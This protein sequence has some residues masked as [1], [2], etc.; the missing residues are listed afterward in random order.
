MK[1]ILTFKSLVLLLSTSI[2]AVVLSI[3]SPTLAAGL[4]RR[5]LLTPPTD[6]QKTTSFQ[7]LARLKITL[8]LAQSQ[9]EKTAVITST[10]EDFEIKKL[11]LQSA[12]GITAKNFENQLRQHILS[13][14]KENLKNQEIKAQ[15]TQGR[16]T[17]KEALLPEY[18]FKFKIPVPTIYTAILSSNGRFLFLFDSYNK[19]NQIV[20]MNT[21]ASEPI[22]WAPQIFLKDHILFMQDQQWHSLDLNTLA[23]KPLSTILTLDWS[24]SFTV[25]QNKEIVADFNDVLQVKN[26]HFIFHLL[27]KNGSLVHRG[28]IALAET[29]KKIPYLSGD[30]MIIETAKKTYNYSFKTQLLQ[31]LDLEPQQNILPVKGTNKIVTNYMRQTAL[32]DLDTNQIQKRVFKDH[33]RAVY[34]HKDQILMKED[35]TDSS[36][37]YHE[38][39]PSDFMTSIETYTN[40][41]EL[42]VKEIPHTNWL[43]VNNMWGSWND[44]GGIVHSKDLENK[45]FSFQS[46]YNPNKQKIHDLLISPDG[47]RIIVQMTNRHTNPSIE[48]W[49]QK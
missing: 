19:Q 13:A 9:G 25:S 14:Q 5:V 47:K 30:Y 44:N 21:G 35:E 36:F 22:E 18:R 48:I 46:I 31:Q 29:V 37:N 39:H 40:S 43:V 3:S 34:A 4:C 28:E 32:V 49:D 6:A 20:R 15:E 41:P 33:T 2:G 42:L 12:L 8:D 38:I 10:R 7:S 26:G 45:L 11:E 24:K 17:T 1:K 23:T 27:D 16:Q